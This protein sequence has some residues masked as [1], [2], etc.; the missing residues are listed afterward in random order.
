MEKRQKMPDKDTAPQLQADVRNELPGIVL[1]LRDDVQV[2]VSNL[3]PMQWGAK[4]LAECFGRKFPKWTEFS[5]CSSAVAKQRVYAAASGALDYQELAMETVL[6]LYQKMRKAGQWEGILWLEHVVYDET[7]LTVRVGFGDATKDKQVV[8]LFVVERKW[9]MVFRKQPVGSTGQ[10]D[11]ERL[12]ILEGCCSAGVRGA[13]NSTG[14]TISQVLASFPGPSANDLEHF[15]FKVRCVETDEAGA[16]MGAESLVSKT[17]DGCDW[18]WLVLLC[19]GHKVHSSATK[20]WSLQKNLIS[21]LIHTSKHLSGSGA[22]ASLKASLAELIATTLVVLP[23]APL[24]SE[25][26][27]YRQRLTNLFAPPVAEPRRRATFNVLASFLNGDWRVEGSLLHH[28]PGQHCCSTREHSI[29]KLTSLLTRVVSKLRPRMFNR[30]NWSSWTD[31]C[32][33]FGLLG[34]HSVVSDAYQKCF[35]ASGLSEDVEHGL[36]RVGEHSSARENVSGIVDAETFLG[37]VDQ[38]NQD[39]FLHLPDPAVADAADALAIER[40]RAALSLRVS[41]SFMRRG[42]FKQVY[43][44]RQVLEAER[45]LMAHLLHTVAG[46]WEI[47]QVVR[48]AVSGD[49]QYRLP[50]Y[51]EAEELTLFFRDLLDTW[52]SS[53]LWQGFA[54]TEAFRTTLFQLTMRLGSVCYQLVK[55]PTRGFPFKLFKLLLPQYATQAFAQEVLQTRTCLL[56]RFSRDLLRQFNT[57]EALLSDEFK[58]ILIAVARQGQGTTFTTERLHSK[59]LKTSLSRQ[60]HRVDV[61]HLALGHAC[62]AA[63]SWCH[64]EVPSE[65][66]I[67][68]PRGR[69]PKRPVDIDEQE[70]VKKKRRGGGGAFRAFLH[71]ELKGRSFKPDVMQEMKSRYAALTP[72]QRARYIE[73]GQAGSMS[74]RLIPPPHTEPPPPP[75][76]EQQL[77]SNSI[78][79]I[80]NP[81]TNLLRLTKKRGP[82]LGLV[83]QNP[84]ASDS[85]QHYHCRPRSI[86]DS[87]ILKATQNQDM[88][89]SSAIYIPLKV[90]LRHHSGR[91]FHGGSCLCLHH[92]ALGA[93]YE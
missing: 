71:M 8:K 30:A 13:A 2:E 40:A 7:P 25:V 80:Q 31:A 3:T 52:W 84:H 39:P 90:H 88:C 74:R 5:D 72:E 82:P 83:I 58:A 85:F 21:G 1:P 53:S 44:F 89:M 54:S 22:M 35:G 41:A 37:A 23:P 42:M 64:F 66:Q 62:W 51:V 10:S 55:V 81:S 9:S 86:H 77:I 6:Q 59:N 61:D 68:K 50:M 43:L 36:M 12:C 17:R 27:A 79:T 75:F 18:S 46:S 87:S 11:K 73:L 33:F 91:C 4:R 34:I 76:S 67:R 56:D 29:A 24:P 16:N 60:T 63:P 32:R 38:D 15:K 49:R 78:D 26:Q 92:S 93:T 47:E 48:D 20:T 69:P 45:R 19:L 65:Q 57:P 70:V 14:D 28:S